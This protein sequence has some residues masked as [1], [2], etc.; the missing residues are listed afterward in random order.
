[1]DWLSDSVVNLSHFT[2]GYLPILSLALTAT[3]LVYGG[4]PALARSTR[5]LGRFPAAIRYLARSALTLSVLGLVLYYVP[6]WLTQL[7]SLFNNLT[8]APVLL[9]VLILVGVLADRNS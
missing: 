3:L 7:L 9:V 2:R 4:K 6:Q 5:W 8:F 1:M